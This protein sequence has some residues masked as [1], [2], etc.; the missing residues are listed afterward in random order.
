MGR[1]VL[2]LISIVTISCGVLQKKGKKEKKGNLENVAA[3]EEPIGGISSQPET[4]KPETH[5]ANN[6]ATP[7]PL[8]RY[9]QWR[10]RPYC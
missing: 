5:T 2:I 8:E 7:A 6:A 10:D 1:W 3:V 9:K 4:P